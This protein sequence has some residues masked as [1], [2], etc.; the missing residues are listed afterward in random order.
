MKK[1]LLSAL[2]LTMLVG[3][4]SGGEATSTTDSG[5]STSGTKSVMIATDTDILSMNSSTST[6][7]TSF[8]A[9][10]MCQAGLTQIDG[11]NVV[12]PDLAE[13]W[14]VSDDGLEYT[15]HIREDAK[16]SDGTDLTAND[17]A[18]AWDRLIAPE[19]AS[20]Y[21]FLIDK[22]AETNTANVKDWEVVDDKTFKVT[23]SLPCDFFLSLCAFPSLFP[24]NE[25]YTEAQGDQYALSCDNMIYCGPYKMVEWTS[26][27]SWK[28][29][30]N[31][32]YWDAASYADKVDEA[33]WRVVQ[34][35]SAILDYQAGNIDYVKLTSEVIDDYAGQDDIVTSLSGYAW[36]LSLNFH[37][38]YLANE[39]IRKAIAYAI[40]TEEMCNSVLKDG[41]TPLE[42]IVTKS[43]TANADG[44][45]FRDISGTVV[46]GYDEDKAKEYFEKGCEE[47]GVDSIS[48]EFLY[49]DSDV[50]KNVAAYVMAAL[51]KVGFSTEAKCEPKKSRI[52]DMQNDNYTVALHRW[53]PDY[54]DP[55]TYM[56]LFITGASNNYGHYESNTYDELI[57]KAL[58]TDAADSTQRWADF[59]E[60]EKI[61]VSD[62]VAVVPL[63]QSGSTALQNTKLTGIEY[64]GA[65][66][67]NYRHMILAD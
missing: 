19:T 28:F 67:D 20:E 8:V 62:E 30:K 33:S 56:D 22:T 14:D 26:N 59:A 4:S 31:D 61:L 16:W 49:E 18:Y 48:L 57:N 13:S 1:F 7:G 43:T 6:D 35:Q 17:F 45:D 27:T 41:S 37:N 65:G 64:H 39:N 44:E 60:A 52:Q 32:Q 29:V 3:C 42:G 47:L 9:L 51:E 23:L 12:Q 40:N 25:E 38:E 46:L 50:S 2:A 63:Y 58:T 54:A 21:A 34:G 24:L 15:F 36:F 55:Q 53:G 11:S 5:T 10:T 66:V